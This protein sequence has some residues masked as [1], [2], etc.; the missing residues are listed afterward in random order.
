[1]ARAAASPVGVVTGTV[2]KVDAGAKT[3]VVKTANGAEETFHF[4]SRTVVHGAGAVS[5]GSKDALHGLK[6]GSEVAVHYTVKGTEKTAG[7]IDNIGKDGLEKTEGAVASIDR[8]AKTL[9]LKTAD[10]TKQTYYLADRAARDTGKNIG[11]GAQK[12]GHVTVYY[13]EEAGQKVA[14]FFQGLF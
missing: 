2:Q 5:T 4:A 13:T 8:G 10:G 14:H 9:T 11:M 12:A 6:A 7:E 3:V 1:M